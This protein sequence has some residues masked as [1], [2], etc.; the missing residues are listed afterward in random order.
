MYD[1]AAMGKNGVN[2]T[3]SMLKTQLLQVMEQIGCEKVEDFP[4]YLNTQ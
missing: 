1:V 2:N 4:N 3:S